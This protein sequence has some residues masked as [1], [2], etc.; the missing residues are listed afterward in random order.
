MFWSPHGQ[1]IVLALLK[2]AEGPIE[3]IDTSDF[4]I[5]AAI[6]PEM[7]TDL[8]WDPTGRYVTTAV[9]AWTGKMVN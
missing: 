9:S 7:T 6:S 4:S 1:F 5:M 3:F 2:S 8:E